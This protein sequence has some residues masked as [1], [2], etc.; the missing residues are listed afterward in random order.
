MTV[1]DFKEQ[2][3]KGKAIEK[4]LDTF[5]SQWY[6]IWPAEMPQERRGIDRL[7]HNG[8][9]WWTVEYKGDFKGAETGNAY[10]ETVSVGRYNPEKEF[11][12]EKKGWAFTSCADKLVYYP[13]GTG[14]LYVLD[15]LDI[16]ELVK[17]NPVGGFRSVTVKNKGYQGRGLLVPLQTIESI[18]KRTLEIRE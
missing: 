14:F 17:S 13:V 8:P 4:T 9:K 1:Y 3:K 11:L 10:I 12:V 6:E 15:P 16:R 18:A 2:L 7:F 5:F